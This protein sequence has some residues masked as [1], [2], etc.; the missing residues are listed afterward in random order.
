M[1]AVITNDTK[2]VNTHT[3]THRYT[4]SKAINLSQLQMNH[5]LSKLRRALSLQAVQGHLQKLV[6][7][8]KPPTQKHGETA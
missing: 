7:G 2:Q 4:H 6:L 1:M 8:A 3:Y 5:K